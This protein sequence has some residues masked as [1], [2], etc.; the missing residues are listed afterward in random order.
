MD[1]TV[2]SSVLKS[3]LRSSFLLI[4][5]TDNTV[6][7]HDNASVDAA[8]LVRPDS[9]RCAT[10]PCTSVDSTVHAHPHSIPNVITM[11]TS[12]DSV[13]HVR[14]HPIPCVVIVCTSVDSRVPVLVRP[15]GVLLLVST[16]HRSWRRTWRGRLERWQPWHGRRPSM[17][18]HNTYIISIV[19]R[20]SHRLQLSGR[21]FYVLYFVLRYFTIFHFRLAIYSFCSDCEHVY[22]ILFILSVLRQR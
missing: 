12:V 15:A 4:P 16:R 10:I 9:I 11:C 8:V 14:P 22:Q 6:L 20:H 1:S 17:R 2:L 19:N 21:I 7:V 18:L 5:V 13:V 3:S